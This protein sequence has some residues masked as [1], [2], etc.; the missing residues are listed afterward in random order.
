M[1]SSPP[2]SVAPLQQHQQPPRRDLAGRARRVPL[3]SG[4]TSGAA[5]TTIDASV[6]LAA[7]AEEEDYYGDEVDQN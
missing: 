7:T 1:Y 4:Q 2:A 6:A 3:E 5:A